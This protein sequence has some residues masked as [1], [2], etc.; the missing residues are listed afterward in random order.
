L[1]SGLSNRYQEE[2]GFRMFC[3]MI[4]SLTFL[5]LNKVQDGMEC[6]KQNIS[7]EANDLLI[8]F[9][10]RIQNYKINIKDFL[11]AIVLI[12]ESAVMST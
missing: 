10:T 9:F 11:K 12:L 5:P 3:A 7:N 6:L 4:D 8:N 2:E 1:V